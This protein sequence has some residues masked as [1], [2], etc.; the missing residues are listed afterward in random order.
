M[1]TRVVGTCFAAAAA[2][3][4][5]LLASLPPGPGQQ[6]KV[7]YSLAGAAPAAVQPALARATFAGLEQCAGTAEEIDAA[8]LVAAAI[9]ERAPA[10]TA[11][12][13]PGHPAFLAC[14]RAGDVLVA[15]RVRYSGGASP[16]YATPAFRV[17]KGRIAPENAAAA[18]LL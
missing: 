8:R 16:D 5:V 1:H 10:V 14:R 15:A 11:I 18:A 4:V 7:D 17:S 12:E 13:E 9:K 2:L 6:T 3:V